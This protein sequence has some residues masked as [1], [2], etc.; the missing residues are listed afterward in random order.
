MPRPCRYA[1]AGFT[2]HVIN[3]GVERRQLFF[4]DGDYNRFLGLM[5]AGKDHAPVKVY[6][7][8]TMRNH[9]HA[10][11]EPE[12]DTALSEYM[13]WVTGT[14]ASDL[15]IRTHTRGLGHVFQQRFWSCPIEDM[16][17][18][19]VVWRYV[20]ANA[21]R[22]GLVDRAEDWRWGSL[23]SRRVGDT[24]LLDHPPY[25]MPKDWAALVNAR[26]FQRELALARVRPRRGRPCTF[27]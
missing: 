15:R 23:Y 21:R 12:T 5:R 8:C 6:S 16:K 7:F 2:F 24:S 10:M 17:H 27:Q 22:A 20:E 13:H 26:M 25:E 11:I 9:F 4:E 18:F 3:R 1:P 14:F 19:F